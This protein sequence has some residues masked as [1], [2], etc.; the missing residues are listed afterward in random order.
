M[1]DVDHFKEYNDTHGHVAGDLCLSKIA[2]VCAESMKRNGD[3]LAR[4]GGEEFAGI[5]VTQ[6]DE[7][8]SIVAERMRAAVSDLAMPHPTN[9]GGIVTISLGTA[10]MRPSPRENPLE[11]VEAAD[12][13]LYAAKSHGRNQVGTTLLTTS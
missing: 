11:L 8:I 2:Q 13:A 3:F 12:S 10:R 6:T 7:D 9:S 1:I 5:L 4:Y